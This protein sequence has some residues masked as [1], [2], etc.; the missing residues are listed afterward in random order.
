MNHAGLIGAPHR[1]I[2][3]QYDGRS[4]LEWAD[5]RCFGIHDRIPG[6]ID[7]R[8]LSA[9]HRALDQR[10][11]AVAARHDLAAV[12]RDRTAGG[13][14]LGRIE[15]PALDIHQADRRN[16]LQLVVQRL[17]VADDDDRQRVAAK[18]P[19]RGGAR[20]RAAH[21]RQAIAIA[22]QIVEAKTEQPGGRDDAGDLARRFDRQREGADQESLGRVQLAV[23]N[24]FGP[25]AIDLMQ[26]LR[27]RAV[28]DF[29]A[30]LERRLPVTDA[31]GAAQ[32]GIGAVRPALLLAQNHEQARVRAA[33]QDVGGD[34]RR[35]VAGVGRQERRVPD[36]DVRLHR[37]GP[38][39]QE[40]VGRAFGWSGGSR[41]R[42][43]GSA[44]PRAECAGRELARTRQRDVA[45]HDQQRAARPDA[46]CGERHDV[47]ARNGLVRRDTRVPAVRIA[48]VDLL[49]ER[50]R[51]DVVRLRQLD[52]ERREEPG[53][54]QLQLLGGER[55]PPADVA[56]QGKGQLGV[57]AQPVGGDGEEVVAGTRPDRPAHPFDFRRDLVGAA[58]G[59]AFGQQLR[60]QTRHSFLPGRVVEVAGAEAEAHRQ[61][62]LLV[63][64]DQQQRHAI[65]ERDILERREAHG[66]QPRGN[67]W[68]GGELLLRG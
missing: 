9:I 31:A 4:L 58:G 14:E 20:P 34:A 56:E 6:D 66:P 37:A 32:R 43:S 35:V 29:G 65:G 30:P 41:R 25:Q 36:D 49:L 51:G 45:G 68:T 44:T 63:V 59:R 61:R 39:H 5:R 47:I 64:L 60:D 10:L 23:G 1:E 2:G 57:I 40:N 28:G 15:R 24:R 50:A 11:E 18:H 13:V 12:E 17:G 46:P 21:A 42:R 38:V 48:A 8:E 22:L 53:P 16:R 27:Q 7:L 55:R 54:R 3:V 33:S 62:W 19:L 26:Q 52:L 67:G